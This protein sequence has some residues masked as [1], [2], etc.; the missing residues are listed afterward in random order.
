MSSAAVKKPEEEKPPESLT[1]PCIA[2]FTG[3]FILVLTVGAAVVAGD[4]TFNVTA[5]ACSLMVG[6]YALGAVSGAN[7]NP[8]VT[9]ALMLSKKGGQG[10]VKKGL[11]YMGSQVAGGIVA[12]LVNMILV[13]DPINLE[14]GKSASWWQAGLAEIIYTFMLCFVVLNV[15]CS[16]ETNSTKKDDNGKPSGNEFFGLAIGFVIVAGGYGAGHLSGGAFNPA[17]AIAL[18]LSS[19]N[20]GF[21][22]CLAYMVFEFIGAA[23]AV[24]LH[25]VV[26]PTEYD[27]SADAKGTPAVLLSEFL[28]TYMLVLTVGLNVLGG[29]AAPVWSI[30]ASL[31]CMIFALGSVSGGHFN[32][33]VTT[34][35]F[36]A[37]RDPTL[38][39][40]KAG[41]YIGTQLA[42]GFAG[43]LTYVIMERGNR[44]PLGPGKSYDAHQAY[45]AELLYTFLLCFVVLCVATVTKTDVLKNYFALAIGSCVTVGGYAIGA[46]SGGSLN[47]AVSFGIATTGFD[48]VTTLLHCI[49]Y[50]I[51]ELCA[52]AMAAGLFMATHPEEYLAKTAD[53]QA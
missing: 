6:I 44:F 24:V 16:P 32:P 33:A 8:A 14:P 43:A 25:K 11:A 46:I 52:G 48:G 49:V 1:I 36:V 22:W 26:R 30:A 45:L 21:G 15:A 19:V 38:T 53:D 51:V 10:E 41:M 23:L 37:K 2:E 39:P 12:S 3:T 5:I 17:V 31:M 27:P 50:I 7:F 9:A 13:L 18:D 42:G 4:S 34:A 40:G 47:P 29:S 35:V 28:G 20:I